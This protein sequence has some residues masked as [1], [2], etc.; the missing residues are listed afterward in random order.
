[1]I[2]FVVGLFVGGF[3]GVSTMA[4][5]FHAS[6]ADDRLEKDKNNPDIIKHEREMK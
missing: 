5:C 4:L 3:V 2:W 6:A 1:M